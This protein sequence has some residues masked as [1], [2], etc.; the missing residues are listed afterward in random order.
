MSFVRELLFYA[1]SF[2]VSLLKK[3]NI[4]P[5]N[6]LSQDKQY[7]HSANYPGDKGGL[8]VSCLGKEVNLGQVSEPAIGEYPD[9]VC[10]QFNP[11]FFTRRPV[12]LGVSLFFLV[13]L[14]EVISPIAEEHQ[15]YENNVIF[16]V[17]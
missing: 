5:E 3:E 8:R 13:G 14:K 17:G 15:D 2:G 12:V 7:P 11:H 4:E 10:K 6:D 9:N 16:S 1:P